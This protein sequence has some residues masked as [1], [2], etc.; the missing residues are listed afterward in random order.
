M[1]VLLS[2]FL[3]AT[4]KIGLLRNDDDTLLFLW[5]CLCARTIIDGIDGLVPWISYINIDSLWKKHR[6]ET[7][8]GSRQCVDP[9][10]TLPSSLYIYTIG[11]GNPQGWNHD[12]I[13]RKSSVSGAKSSHNI[14][15]PL[16]QRFRQNLHTLQ[17]PGQI[18]SCPST[19]D[20]EA[21]HSVN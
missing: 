20:S 12:S 14:T 17:L 9:F 15:E 16:L 8:I 19:I 6:V 3:G 13:I 7:Y 4:E 1:K 21:L 5:I 2:C 11:S 18:L 10:C